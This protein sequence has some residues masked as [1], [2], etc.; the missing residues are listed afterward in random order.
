MAPVP[1]ADAVFRL[2][3]AL[4]TLPPE[5]LDGLVV[6]PLLG[7]EQPTMNPGASPLRAP[8]TRMSV[9]SL[10]PPPGLPINS[11]I[12]LAIQAFNSLDAVDVRSFREMM[13]NSLTD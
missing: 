11:T 4:H 12:E 10:T 7:S 6:V 1:H 2:V 13:S 5:E 9:L 3:Q 8:V